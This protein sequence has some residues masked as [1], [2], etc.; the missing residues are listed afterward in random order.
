MKII[1][2]TIIFFNI[3][4]LLT[5]GQNNFIINGGFESAVNPELPDG[6]GDGH[7]GIR[8]QWQLN[9]ELWRQCFRSETT[10][11]FE[12]KRSLRLEKR[13]D[14][15]T[16]AAYSCYIMPALDLQGVKHWTFSVYA[17]APDGG[18]IK[19]GILTAN[20][21]KRIG[22][23][24]TFDLLPGEWT[25]I[26]ISRELKNTP[27]VQVRIMPQQDGVYF[28]D[29]VQFEENDL[30]E[31]KPSYLNKRWLTPAAAYGKV[32]KFT[33]DPNL[34]DT[35]NTELEP[36]VYR[37]GIFYRNNQPFMP[38]FF[39]SMRIPERQLLEQ[40]REYG[41][42]GVTSHQHAKLKETETY[43]MFTQAGVYIM[44]V[45]RSA[46]PFIKEII[47]TAKTSP[48][49]VAWKAWDEPRD[50]F[51]AVLLQQV[52]LIKNLDSI[53]PVVI[54]W[55][56]EETNRFFKCIKEFPG[57]VYCSDQYPVGCILW[58]G[59]I[60]D[61]ADFIEKVIK[62]LKPLD[63]AIWDW[64]QITG[65]AYMNLREPTPAEFE[66][67]IYAALIKGC[68]GFQMFQHQSFSRDLWTTV[69]RIG[70]EFNAL[71][72]VVYAEES[73]LPQ[74]SNDQIIMLSRRYQGANYLICVNRSEQKSTVDFAIPPDAEVVFENRK[75][76]QS[77]D[78]FEPYQRHIYRWE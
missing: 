6:W 46:S 24:Q 34:P 31:Y 44:P 60:F 18:K 69:C 43:Q 57:D 20:Q 32:E 49:V 37:D 2:T 53:R 41:F 47:E 5:A 1:S 8:N 10:E 42:N 68:R 76:H 22:T 59:S 64:F 74:C 71:T 40:L 67:M 65:N 15:P 50:P 29:A 21:Y 54:T 62:G 48:A 55:R 9:P 33:P 11:V 13:P 38:Y 36:L 75:L 45:F 72:P 7:W 70:L 25:R 58:P 4:F 19:L 23:E 63:K 73:P 61:T 27:M 28:L 66:G 39:G 14:L 52:E 26:H 30:S 17:K 16:L 51:A 3:L 12:G 35:I 56:T 77:S 78:S